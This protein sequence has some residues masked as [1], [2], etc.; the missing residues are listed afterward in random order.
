MKEQE[1]VYTSSNVRKLR[2]KDPD[3]QAMADQWEQAFKSKVEITPT[4]QGG[5][6]VKPLDIKHPH[7]IS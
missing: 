3:L 4:E 2:E 6:K 7:R 5:I 1:I